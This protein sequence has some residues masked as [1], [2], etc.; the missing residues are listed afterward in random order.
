MPVIQGLGWTFDT[1]ASTYEKLRP[2]YVEELY[3]TLF[4]YIPID[5]CSRV[6]EVG[7]GGGQA[8]APVLQ[9]GCQMTA[10]ECGERFSELLKEKFRAVPKFSV[11]TKRFEETEWKDESVDLVFSASAFHW[12]PEKAGY[13]KV[14]A[15]LK[16]GGA[17]ARFANHPFR[18]KGNPALSEEIDELYHAYYDRFHQRK[19]EAIR[20][21][22]EKDARERALIAGKYGFSDL[23]YHL[24]Y[25]QRVFSASEYLQLLG[26]YSDHIVIDESIRKPFFEAIAEAINR[27]GGTITLYDT[28][29]L[30][31]ARK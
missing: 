26:T 16:K 28:I 2:G 31:L 21:Y 23:R 11:I 8:T 24:F 25:R 22:T 1:V 9:T 30:Q 15:M 27:H 13:E 7:S 12:V 5:E 20:E 3:R 6:V 4:A 18:D 10:V 19:R 17:F 14:F 29:D